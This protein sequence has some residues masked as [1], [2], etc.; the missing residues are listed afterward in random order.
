[1]GETNHQFSLFNPATDGLTQV[2]VNGGPSTLYPKD[3]KNF[4]PRLSLAD[5]LLG[6][7]KLVLRT[8]SAF[9]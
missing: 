2:G 7:G 5:D 9:L 3:W 8:V 4:A 6:N 1:V